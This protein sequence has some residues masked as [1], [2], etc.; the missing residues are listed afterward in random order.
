MARG[1]WLA[2]GLAVLTAFGSAAVQAQNRPGNNGPMP[3]DPGYTDLYGPRPPDAP[4]QQQQ[5]SGYWNTTWGAIATDNV[6]G[7]LG[8]VAGYPSQQVAEAESRLECRRKG[9][10]NCVAFA[11]YNQC[12]VMVL[13]DKSFT[14]FTA[15]NIPTATQIGMKKCSA[16]QQNCRVYHSACTNPVFVP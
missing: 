14:I 2:V 3:G 11:Y 7:I 16:E 10:E 15:E 4:P 12:A 6:K 8:S 5:P 9:G 13:G 1:T